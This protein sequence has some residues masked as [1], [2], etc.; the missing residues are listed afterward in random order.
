ML[1]ARDCP[2]H[3][4]SRLSEPAHGPQFLAED[5]AFRK[6]VRAFIAE[7][8]EKLPRNLG[9]PEGATRTK[10]DYLPGTSFSTRRAGWRRSGPG[11]MAA[12]AGTS[13]SAT[14]STRDRRGRH[15]DHTAVR[16]SMVGPVIFNYG[17]DEQKQK[18]LPRI[19]SA[20]TGGARAIPS[21]RRL[22]ISRTCAPR[23][24]REGDHYIVKAR[25]RGRRSPV[26][27]HDL[28]P[29]AAPIPM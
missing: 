9:A 26:R 8:K 2:Y 27:R 3:R 19:L 11:N 21:R 17:N 14:S 20:R 28:L 12:R 13:L 1:D 7:A 25:R 10:E 22:R 5:E 6:E 29:R 18:Y 24:V 16:L 15:A 4:F 23:A